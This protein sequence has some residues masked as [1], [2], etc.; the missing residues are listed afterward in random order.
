MNVFYLPDAVLGMVSFS[1]EE[2]KHCVKVLRMQ[3][4]DRF[5]VTNGKG[6]LFDGEL[7]ENHPKGRWLA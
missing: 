4:G 6:S 3:V 5:C 1:E 7:V 2:S